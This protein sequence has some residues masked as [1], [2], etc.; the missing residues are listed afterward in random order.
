MMKKP[1]TRFEKWSTQARENAAWYQHEEVGYNYRMSNVVAGVVRGQF[2]FLDEHIAQ[3][4]Q[5]IK[6]IKR[7]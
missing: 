3:K 5:F 1:Q 6:D 7:D 4:K 2:T